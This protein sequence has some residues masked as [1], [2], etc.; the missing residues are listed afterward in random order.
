MTAEEQ[1]PVSGLGATLRRGA[2]ISAL[3]LVIVQVV[4]LAQT[5]VIARL[6]TPTEI[7]LF[8]AG[9]VLTGFLVTFSEGGMSSA[10]IQRE[11]DLDD[12]A[13][14]VFRVTLVNGLL[15]SLL[16]LAA[17][18]LVA[19]VFD[20]RTAGVVAAITSGTLLLH[21]L[22]IV[23]DSLMQRRFDFRRRL[24]VNPGITIS[25]AVTAVVLAASGFGIWSM[26]VAMYASQVTWVVL[27]WSLCGWRP[28]R[29][30]ASVR[31]WRELARY[32][33]PLVISDVA[34]R[35]RES[36]ET[37]VVG[38]A[39]SGEALGL[40]RYGRRLSML[41]AVAVVDIGSYVLFPAFSRIAGDAERFRAAFLRA[42]SW[43]WFAAAPLAALL[44]AI[45]EPLVVVLLG[46]Q[47]RGSGIALV[48]L[49][50]YGL[51]EAMG[52]V[53]NESIKGSGRSSLVNWMTAVNLV[54]GVVL[55]V[56]LV[57]YGLPGVGLAI[58]VSSLLMGVTGLAI[59][60]RVVGVGIGAIVRRMSPAVVGAA[61]ALAAVAPLEHLVLHSDGYGF[62]PGLGLILLDMAAFAM[63]YLVAMRLLAPSLMRT[64]IDGVR[65]RFLRRGA[66]AE[67]ISGT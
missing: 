28:G 35:A 14:T 23:P 20:S 63:V 62:L 3:S 64:L 4:G 49:A 33:Y 37:V 2:A 53:A 39:L 15:M 9:T 26:V 19:A 44:V 17:A 6:L 38:R 57:P 56:V 46:E 55:L 32:A 27:T 58:S 60:A 8:Y 54:S 59:A 7:G 11:R 16:A 10:L 31:L 1:A 61:L 65:S 51:G 13:E 48:F 12:T 25:F 67:E 42:L 5:L 24:I 30:R 47:W 40:Y 43:I 22:T 41:P 29:G 34:W 36:F 45:G 21:G 18:P 52:A 50:G 66:G